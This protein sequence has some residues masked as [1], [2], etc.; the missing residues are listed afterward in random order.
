MNL[1]TEGEQADN[2]TNEGRRGNEYALAR[3]Q[4]LARSGDADGAYQVFKEAIGRSPASLNLYAPAAE[5]MLGRKQGP[6]ALEFAEQGLKQSR[7]QN[8]RDA[9]QQFLELIEAARK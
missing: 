3:G 5:A 4:A 6:R 9:E 8:N 2:A 7:L 1:L